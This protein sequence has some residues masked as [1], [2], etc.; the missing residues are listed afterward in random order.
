MKIRSLLI[1]SLLF[2]S[3]VSKAQYRIGLVPRISPDKKVYQKVGFTEIE[4]A[5]GSPSVRD[6]KVLGEL[7]PFDKVWRAG[8]NDATRFKTSGDLNFDGQLL[9]AGE[10]SFFIKANEDE[11]WE[12]IFN[13][14]VKQWGAFR[15]DSSEDTLRVKA[16]IEPGSFT[17]ELSYSIDQTSHDTAALV[18]KWENI[19]LSLPFTINYKNE[20]VKNID[21]QV[22]ET[23][24]HLK[25][26]IYVQGAE[27]L[28][29]N[30]LDPTQAL[31]WIKQAEILEPKSSTWDDRF[32]PI[33]YIQ[34]HRNWTKAKLLASQG[35]FTKALEEWEK[36]NGSMFYEKK[37][38]REAFEELTKEWKT[39][40]R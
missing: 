1:L 35:M 23:K 30:D 36:V 39:K 21:A 8:A 38:D 25:W 10:Y 11:K 28:S 15:Y 18:M 2:S 7:I 9:P 14:Q 29:Q 4:I 40:K 13:K 34:Q 26:V 19:T 27:H 17:E 6:R 12:C 16:K 20:F 3:Y 22:E 32:Y 37:K 31:E 33:E 24:D 5:Y